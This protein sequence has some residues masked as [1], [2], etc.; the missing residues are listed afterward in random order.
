[1][2]LYRYSPIENKEKL[3][4]AI[5]YVSRASTELYQKITGESAP[6]SSLTI[7]AH[8]FDE[9]EKLKE[10]QSTMGEY[11]GE[12]LGPRVVLHERI[13]AGKNT[14]THL[15]IRKPDPYHS[16]VGSN[17]YDIENYVAFKEK[18]L[19]SKSNNLRLQNR[20]EYELIEFWDPDFDVLGY[21]LSDPARSKK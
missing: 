15:R 19:A 18:F 1:M 17:D 16:H 12:V 13:V 5:L 11:V 4:E 14:I 7:F 20:G 8:N 6:I 10:I 9:F 2:Q 21:V 3:L